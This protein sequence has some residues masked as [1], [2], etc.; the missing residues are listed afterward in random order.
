MHLPCR[1]RVERE[2]VDPGR[3]AL[4]LKGAL[5]FAKVA[6]LVE[7]HLP[8]LDVGRETAHA[9]E[10]AARRHARKRVV[11]EARV[12]CAKYVALSHN[13]KKQ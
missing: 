4:E 8:H 5:D 11:H 2:V 7:A 12:H 1:V 6:N 9:E 3:V 13:T 10:A